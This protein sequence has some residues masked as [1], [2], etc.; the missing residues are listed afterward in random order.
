[1]LVHV[2]AWL[3]TPP[4]MLVLENSCTPSGFPYHTTA[5]NQSIACFICDKWSQPAA[6]LLAEGGVI[7]SE[8]SAIHALLHARAPRRLWLAWERERMPFLPHREHGQFYFLGFLAMDGRDPVGIH[9]VRTM[10][11][12]F[13]NT[14]I[15]SKDVFTLGPKP[16]HSGPILVSLGVGLIIT[17]GDRW[18]DRSLY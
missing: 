5:R 14:I 9:D 10:Q 6:S 3:I 18:I 2:D 17:G 11:Q 4:K 16:L 13:K 15:K 8:E 12:F 1:M 7:H